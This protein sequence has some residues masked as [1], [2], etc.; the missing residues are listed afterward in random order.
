MVL[1]SVQYL[2]DGLTRDGQTTHRRCLLSV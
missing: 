1:Y 2:K